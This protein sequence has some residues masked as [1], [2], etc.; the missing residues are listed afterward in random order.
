MDDLL[1]EFLT[2][3]N[4]S[5]AE[6]DVEL[7]QLEQNPNDKELLGNIFRLMHTIKG[8]C[9]FLG[10]PRLESVAHAG[11]NVL[12]KVRDGELVVTPVAVTLILECLDSIRALLEQLEATEA[13]PEG[14]DTDL[15]ARLNAFADGN[16]VAASAAAADAPVEEAAAEAPAEEDAGQTPLDELELA[17]QNAKGPAELAAEKAAQEA[18]QEAAAADD[19]P[20][21]A[22]APAPAKAAAPKKEAAA[23]KAEPKKAQPVADADGGA[24]KE[25]S[26]ANQSLRVN[27]D[28]LENLMTMVSELVLTRNQL[29]QILRGQS[30]S[31]FAAPL[32]RLNHVVSELQEGVM[33][34]RMQPIGNAWAK[35]PRI[36]RDLGQELDKKIDLVMKGAE[37]ELDRQVLELI[38]DPLTHMVRNSAD[39]GLETPA[40]RL[41]AGKPEI[42][43]VMLNAFH[44]GGHIII[45][46]ADDGK[47]LSVAKIKQ[48]CIDNGIASESELEQMSEQQVQQ[49]IFKAGFSTAA[50]VTSVSGRGVGM[51]V[52]RTNIEK[53]GGTIELTSVEGR[54]TKFVIKI[55]LTLAI[56]SALI[57]ECAGERFAIPQLSVV[58]LVRASAH[59]EHTI[60]RINGTPVLRLRN[61]LLPLVH[62]RHL[63]K[64]DEPSISS[65]KA[66]KDAKAA[67]SGKK[68]EV[69][70]DAKVTKAKPA[71]EAVAQDAAPAAAATAVPAK[72]ADDK[73]VFIVVAQIGTYSMGIIVDRVFDTE[74][75][76][77]KPVAPILR[78]LQ[79]FS[80]NTILG[81][82]SVVMIL[83][84]NGIA[85]ATGEIS[86]AESSEADG[87]GRHSSSS[88]DNVAMLIF[89]AVDDTPKAVPLALVARLEEIDLKQV[90]FSNNQYVVQ[91]RGQLMPLVMMEPG[92]RLETEG[93]QPVLVFAD[94]HRTMGLV[95]K[96]I[97][98]IVEG[99]MNIELSSEREGYVGTAVIGGKA[100]DIIDAGY[101]LTQ[102]F[103]DWFVSDR[104]SMD[105][106]KSGRR[107]LVVDDSPFFRNLLQPLLTVAGY[108][109]VCVDSADAALDLCDA[110]ED[111]DVIISDIEMP[112]MNG[113]EFASKVT[114]DSRWSNTPIVA[115]SAFSNPKD[116]A[117]GR[118]AGFRDY[119]AKTD[120]DALLNTLHDTLAELRGA[121]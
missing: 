66:Q 23:K 83:D 10:L 75:I 58:E 67:K 47:G 97:V 107:L 105:G 57:V 12:G 116:L 98:D 104:D 17:F 33:A 115:L 100:T 45:E 24:K 95:V 11:E 37:T 4:E 34:T 15:I 61:R 27:V 112:G 16:G 41:A 85:A 3:T 21:P 96:E 25:G 1:S 56:V 60:E 13:E 62:L 9:G 59:T 91:Y 119:V 54:G 49:F 81:D 92:Q 90:E 32:Q 52:V 35:L 44:E 89:H 63:L 113:F 30:E 77:V 117:R 7:V 6:L 72:G 8:T 48:K 29:L 114:K 53:I 84:P 5:L 82:G 87:K 14:E 64:L 120:R 31:E 93:R 42:G 99:R 51:D 101:F 39:H 69:A 106:D 22:A 76:V 80:G 103:H 121:A 109:V 55:P 43:S 110:G 78:N 73:E 70:K 18:A 79:L 40:E 46:I 2:E 88:A 108:E 28:V 36:V 118:E 102:A 38:K 94:R 111:F 26:V 19:K 50:A 68:A 20:E 71:D 86:V 74:E 65:K